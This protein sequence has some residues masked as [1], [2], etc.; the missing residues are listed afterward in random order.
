MENILWGINIA[1]IGAILL[2]IVYTAGVVWRVEMKLDTSYKFFLTAI[3]LLFLAETADFYYGLDNKFFWA[4]AVKSLRMLFAINFLVGIL[5]MRNI[6]RDLD[7][8]KNI[9]K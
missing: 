5:L 7:G 4:L 8:E 6:V 3:I 1:T 2:S 9:E